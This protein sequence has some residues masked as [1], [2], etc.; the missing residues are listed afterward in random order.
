MPATAQIA[1]IWQYPWRPAQLSGK[2]PFRPVR[3]G[4]ISNALGR[5][6]VVLLAAAKDNYGFSGDASQLKPRASP[7]EAASLPSA[8]LL[9]PAAPATRRLAT[10]NL[11]KSV[12]P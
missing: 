4:R 9:N 12:L 6:N 8:Y 2:R 10:H 3:A 7:P 11:W 1:P 5:G